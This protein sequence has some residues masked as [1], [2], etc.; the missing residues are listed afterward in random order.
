ME[1]FD[2]TIC[3]GRVLFQCVEQL[4]GGRICTSYLLICI[5]RA[6]Y[7][8]THLTKYVGKYVNIFICT[9]LLTY[10]F[11]MFMKIKE[12]IAIKMACSSDVTN[13]NF[14]VENVWSRSVTVVGQMYAMDTNV[15]LLQA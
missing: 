3:H 10:C 6:H 1:F 14:K 7:K 4:S 15:D 13:A 8:L 2:K 9:V 11:K 5:H 12:I